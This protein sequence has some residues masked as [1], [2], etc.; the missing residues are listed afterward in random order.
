MLGKSVQGFLSYDRTDTQTDKQRLRLYIKVILGY[1]NFEKV[2]EIFDNFSQG[3]RMGRKRR[4]IN[5]NY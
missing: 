3:E 4:G 2:R 1:R 5:G